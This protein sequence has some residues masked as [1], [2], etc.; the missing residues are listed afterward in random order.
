MELADIES[1]AAFF[2]ALHKTRSVY[3]RRK[4]DTS[5]IS[6]RLRPRKRCSCGSCSS[7]LDDARWERIFREK[8]ADP[9][10]YTR[11][12]VSPGSSLAGCSP[13]FETL[14]SAVRNRCGGW[15]GAHRSEDQFKSACKNR[16]SL[17][18]VRTRSCSGA[19]DLRCT[20]SEK[21]ACDCQVQSPGVR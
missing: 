21:A 13:F 1:I 2:P 7:C 18:R 3:V 14:S 6:A 10:Y 15:G 9:E 16:P 17:G 11:R 12:A 19:A 8:F 20:A 4:I 5:V